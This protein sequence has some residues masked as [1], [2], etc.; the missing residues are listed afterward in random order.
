MTDLAP[1]FDP[2]NSPAGDLW[3]NRLPPTHRPA[4]AVRGTA[5]TAGYQVTTRPGLFRGFSMDPGAS[6][7]G[8]VTL[9]D[10]QSAGGN[11]LAVIAF[12]DTTAGHPPLS[13]PPEGVLFEGGL[14]QVNSAAITAVVFYLTLL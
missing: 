2:Y 11:P 5:G 1:S 7:A 6:F 14:W 4:Q 12:D 9:Y 3:A 8:T 13:I 10:G